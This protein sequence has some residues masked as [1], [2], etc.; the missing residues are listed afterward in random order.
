M[1]VEEIAAGRCDL[2]R[3]GGAQGIA[4]PPRFRGEPGVLRTGF[5]LEPRDLFGREIAV[6]PAVDKVF[7][8]RF[9]D[10]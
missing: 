10:S 2:G 7:V 1:V 5:R 9:H 3:G 8:W 4:D 6:D